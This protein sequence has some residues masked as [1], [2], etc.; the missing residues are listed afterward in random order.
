[1]SLMFY[2]S[3]LQQQDMLSLSPFLTVLFVCVFTDVLRPL[4]RGH[5]PVQEPAHLFREHH[6]DVPREEEA[7]D[8][9]THLR[10]L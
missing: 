2:G 8:A 5:Q 3:A 7:R 6:R 9:S 10:H 1:M 4:L